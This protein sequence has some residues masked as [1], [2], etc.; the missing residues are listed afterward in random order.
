V[1]SSTLY[2]PISVTELVRVELGGSRP[3]RD[4]IGYGLLFYLLRNRFYIGEVKYKGD[5]LPGEQPPI[6]DRA[7]FDAVQ[8]KLTDQWTT[9]TS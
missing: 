8:Q 3:L 5:I 6:M 1:T 7:L 2:D 4:N 9:R